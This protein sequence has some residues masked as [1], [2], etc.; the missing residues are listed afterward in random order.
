MIIF[1]GGQARAGTR[2]TPRQNKNTTDNSTCHES[3][4]VSCCPFVFVVFFVDAGNVLDGCEVEEARAFVSCC[5]CPCLCSVLSVCVFCCFCLFFCCYRFLAI[6]SFCCC[7]VFTLLSS[8]ILSPLN[9]C[10]TTT[11]FESCRQ[12]TVLL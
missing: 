11:L 1:L 6:A 5:F 7:F 9:P 8:L 3:L 2:A 12:V 4:S 10:P